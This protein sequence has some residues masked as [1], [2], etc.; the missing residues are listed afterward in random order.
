[1]KNTIIY[2]I[3]FLFIS[4][5]ISSQTNLIP[6]TNS[7]TL[8][9]SDIKTTHLL[10]NESIQYV[11]VGS[12]FFVADTLQNMVRLKHIGEELTDIKSLQSNLTIITDKGS[13]YSI[14]LGFN[15]Y[16]ENLNF[17]V[18]KSKQI[19]PSF[20]K[21][22]DTQIE[23]AQELSSICSTIDEL[24]SNLKIYNNTIKD[25]LDVKI[26]GFFYIE[27][28]IAIKMELTNDSGIDFDIDQIIFRTKLDKK[29]SAD[30]IYQERIITPINICN[31][32]FEIVGNT[33]NN[34][35]FLFNKFMLNKNEQLYVDVFEQNGGRSAT[36]CIP[37][38]KLLKL[39]IN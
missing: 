4:H 19:I 28:K 15:R 17:E 26:V 38:K 20:K 1:M 8:Y 14:F 22:K 6:L 16:T 29:F 2:T 24:D 18:N 10:F 21:Q 12:P 5:S 39:K 36:V 23:K 7:D 37:R 25:D 32:N 31:T 33:H 27:D 13:Y 3:C 30:Y 11:D 34:F 35:T 9:V